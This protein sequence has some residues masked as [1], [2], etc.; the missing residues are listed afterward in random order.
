MVYF[1]FYKDEIDKIMIVF[2]FFLIEL[3]SILNFIKFWVFMKMINLSRLFY[4]F[5]INI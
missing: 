2:E 3:F 5:I 4:I 1:V